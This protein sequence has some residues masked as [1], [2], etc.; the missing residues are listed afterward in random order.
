[1]F[2]YQWISVI[3]LSSFLRMVS[4]S[5]LG[6]YIAFRI[7]GFTVFSKFE[8]FFIYLFLIFF[9]ISL[10]LNL[11]IHILYIFLYYPTCFWVSIHI[12]LSFY[13]L[14]FSLES[15]YCC[16]LLPNSFILQCLVS[17]VINPNVNSNTICFSFRSLIC[18]FFL[19]FLPVY[20][21]AS[22]SILILGV[23]G[24]LQSIQSFL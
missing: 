13:S 14:W 20:F 9:Y 18:L 5:C 15:F 1:M 21:Y 6:F 17:G 3:T 11:Q 10:I 24:A 4:L 7:S 23:Q 16:V 8:K 22:L 19:V 2:V 12:F